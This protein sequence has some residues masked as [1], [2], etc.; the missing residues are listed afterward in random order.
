ML[1]SLIFFSLECKKTSPATRGG[2]HINDIPNYLIFFFF[3]M[4]GCL[5]HVAILFQFEI[6]LPFLM[7]FRPT[8]LA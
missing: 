3:I 8:I 6:F 1:S 4:H 2:A 7:H 5:I